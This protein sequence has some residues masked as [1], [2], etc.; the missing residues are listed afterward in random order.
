[1]ENIIKNVTGEDLLILAREGFKWK[2]VDPLSS[3]DIIIDGDEN[4]YKMALHAIR[5]HVIRNQ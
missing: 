3:K 4:Y 1:M 5:K 2:P